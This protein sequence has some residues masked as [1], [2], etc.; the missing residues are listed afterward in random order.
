MWVWASTRPGSTVRP[1]RSMSGEGMVAGRG[2]LRWWMWV[3]RPVDGSMVR[4]MEGMK[5]LRVGE[6]RRV[7][8]I[9]RVGIV[10]CGERFRG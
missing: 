9:V 6:K 4:E 10:I 7:V 2:V 5:D 1:R 3:I 8:W